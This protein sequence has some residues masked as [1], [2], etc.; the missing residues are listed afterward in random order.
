M[1]SEQ[2]VAVDN[3]E[4]MFRQSSY[5][6]TPVLFGKFGSIWYLLA[7]GPDAELPPR[8]SHVTDLW[9]QLSGA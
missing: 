2:T 8:E 3:D 6:G 5:R 7:T 9:L 4:I 1:A